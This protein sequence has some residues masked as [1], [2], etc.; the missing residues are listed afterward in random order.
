M[1]ARA[2][3]VCIILL[4]SAGFP[5]GAAQA[6]RIFL[7]V[8]SAA[9]P[10]DEILT[11]VNNLRIEQ[12]LAPLNAHPILMQLAQAQAD[13]IV[14][15]G[16]ITHLSA[17]GRRPF[18]RALAAG[19]PL[20]GDLDL[21]GFYAENIQVGPG[22]TPQGAVEI[23]LGDELHRNTMFSEFRSDMGAGVAVDGDMVYYV[24]DCALAS[25][26]RT[27]ITL[28]VSPAPGQSAYVVVPAATSTPQLDGSIVHVVNTGETLWGIAA[29]YNLTVEQLA[30]LNH[31]NPAR[32]I[33]PGERLVL[34]SSATPTRKAP[35]TS[36]YQQR[37]TER[38]GQPSATPEFAAQ[39]Q[40]E[41]ASAGAARSRLLG[42]GFLLAAALLW[43]VLL[44]LWR[45]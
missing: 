5:A 36:A 8:R 32:F 40:P 31:I 37:L 23:W 17:D 30:Q 42:W 45:S 33:S 26:Y 29:V 13:Y 21:G 35:P 43:V 9:N 7:V 2:F 41:D 44:A 19:Y 1:R 12:G 6:R 27:V 34:R 20:A 15:S 28:A 38:A 11:L 14:A 18:Q 24:L 10:A 16:Q 22:L 25:P 39:P 3:L 4:L